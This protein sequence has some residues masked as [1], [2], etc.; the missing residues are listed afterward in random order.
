[1]SPT[2]LYVIMEHLDGPDLSEWM[3][4]EEVWTPAVVL[5]GDCYSDVNI[6]VDQ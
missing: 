2:F 3:V 6:E 5:M 1:M 4:S